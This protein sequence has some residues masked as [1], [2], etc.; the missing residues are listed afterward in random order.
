MYHCDPAARARRQRISGRRE[1]ILARPTH[2]FPASAGATGTGRVIA[3]KECVQWFEFI[4]IHLSRGDFSRGRQH[5]ALVRGAPKSSCSD[6]PQFSRVSV[7]R[8]QSFISRCSVTAQFSRGGSG[9]CRAQ[10]LLREFSAVSTS[11]FLYWSHRAEELCPS[12]R[13]RILRHVVGRAWVP[14]KR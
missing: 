3:R 2:R 1:L 6:I 13:R 5:P 8:F 9:C 14:L 10:L 7:I 4:F 11:P 12:S